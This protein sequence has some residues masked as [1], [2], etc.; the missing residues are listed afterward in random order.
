MIGKDFISLFDLEP[1]DLKD[2][3]SLAVYLKKRRA[4]GV[5]E[6]ALA[7]K[8]LAMLFEKP[9]LRTRV[10]FEVGM[11]ELGGHALYI[12]KDEVG[13]GQREAV[14]DVARVLSR[15][16]QGI[17]IR[18]FAHSN[19]RKLAES[20]SVPV[21]N[22]LC[23]EAH[24]CQALADMLTVLEHFGRVDGLRIVFIGD[25][26]NVARS[27]AR[28]CVLL[29][30]SFVLACPE[31]YAFTERDQAAF[32][33]HWGNSVVQ[34]HDPDRAVAGAH[35]LYTDVWTSMGQEAERDKRLAAFSGYQIN[36]SLLAKADP[37]VKVLHCLPAHR[38][39][40]ITAEVI[41]APAS[42]VFDQAENRL[43]AQKA[44]M[45]LLMA[46]DRDEVLAAARAEAP[47]N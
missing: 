13:L 33:E 30:S 31:A 26:N 17:M 14:E 18:T 40:E 28:A 4:Q 47:I 6:S 1:E 37:S 39:E 34:V 11:S 41:E 19:V 3:L 2:L 8:H 46:D 38:G 20:G 10:S 43:H 16:V 5:R 35:V 9:S 45:R 23:D 24:P 12:S 22:G 29:G 36:A 7:G 21:I 32:G 44:V 42:V 15:Y 27:L 25:G